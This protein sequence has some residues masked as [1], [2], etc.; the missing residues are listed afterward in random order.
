MGNCYAAPPAQASQE[1]VQPVGSSVK[2]VDAAFRTAKETSL[3]AHEAM[4]KL[5]EGN[6]R[7]VGARSERASNPGGLRTALATD[8]Q[9]PFAIVIGCADSRCPVETTFDAQPGDIFVL[10]NAG[11][12]CPSSEGSIVASS[13]YAVGALGTKLLVVMG[14]TKCGA[15]VGATKMAL[16]PDANAKKDPKSCSALE[17]YLDDLTPAAKEAAKLLG[18]SA[19]SVDDVAAQA[20]R[21][22]VFRTIK[23]L[24]DNSAALR[25]K[26]RGGVELHGAVYDIESGKVEFLGQHPD[27]KQLL[28]GPSSKDDKALGA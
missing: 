1:L 13:E 18:N 8:G 10:R 7:Y 28:P 23:S 26:V 24:L 4:A 17:Q 5:K 14:H 12:A 15:M 22:N 21:L 3:S 27:L 11:N 9:N 6:A 25:E 16:G 2:H 20:I 19:F